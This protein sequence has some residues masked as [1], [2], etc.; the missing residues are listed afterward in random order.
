MNIEFRNKSNKAAK[1]WI[2]S[3]LAILAYFIIF[4]LNENIWDSAQ[5]VPIVL[6]LVQ[7]ISFWSF[8]W[9]YIKSKGYPTFIA[10]VGVIFLTIA[11]IFLLFLIFLPDRFPIEY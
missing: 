11:P 9:F 3:L 1:I 10:L 7:A 4:P 5:V 6:I 2:G 8:L